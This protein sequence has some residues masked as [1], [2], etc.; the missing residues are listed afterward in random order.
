VTKLP[1]GKCP[2][3]GIKIVEVYEWIG[4]EYAFGVTIAVPVDRPRLNNYQM[5]ILLEWL[6]EKYGRDDWVLA[7]IEEPV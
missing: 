4:G 5:Q 3:E 6:G 1:L 2:F 7:A